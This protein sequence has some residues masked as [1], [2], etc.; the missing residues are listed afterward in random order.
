MTPTLAALL[1]AYGCTEDALL[2]SLSDDH[3]WLPDLAPIAS[4]VDGLSACPLAIGSTAAA[5]ALPSLTA[6]GLQLRTVVRILWAAQLR[7]GRALQ[8]Y[9][10]APYPPED[11]A[12]LQVWIRDAAEI[13]RVWVW[14]YC[15]GR[16]LSDRWLAEHPSR[17]VHAAI[18]CL[19][20][21]GAQP[22]ISGG[23]PVL[24]E[25]RTHPAA[26]LPS[27]PVTSTHPEAALWRWQRA[28]YRARREG[29]SEL[30]IHGTAQGRRYVH[31]SHPLARAAE[32][33]LAAGWEDCAL[34][35][36]ADSRKAR[37]ARAA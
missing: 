21:L 13:P 9:P 27:F 25:D 26:Q 4:G 36:A 12:P 3:G 35:Q 15:Y 1:D 31:P 19:D 23:G 30:A 14:L 24:G 28:V 17:K 37:P 7:W 10:H 11:L 18:G 16:A 2:E 32:A 34:T 5:A 33:A 20:W 6:V 8:G 22:A 29:I